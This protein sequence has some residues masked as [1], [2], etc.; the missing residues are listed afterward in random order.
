MYPDKL[1]RLKLDQDQ[2]EH[3]TLDL[4]ARSKRGDFFESLVTILQ[5]ACGN[6]ATQSK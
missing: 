6:R 3:A 4:H 2:P 1:S 5:K